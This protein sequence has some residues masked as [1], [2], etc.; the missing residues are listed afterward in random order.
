M[1]T[2][3]LTRIEQHRWHT[4]LTPQFDVTCH[5][6]GAGRAE[7]W[8][9]FVGPPGLDQLDEV[10]I[11]IRD[12][13]RGREAFTIAGGPTAEQIGQQVWG[14]YRFQPSADGADSNGR[15]VAPIE[16]ILGDQRRFA[17]QQ[18]PPPPWSNDTGGWRQQQAGQSVRLTFT[19]RRDGYEPWHVPRTVVVTP[20][21]PNVKA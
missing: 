13:I 1:A 15:S 8:V 12:D 11:T 7:L 20:K 9:E 2:E 19:C 3:R 17:L 16:L 6:T 14:P 5:E 4:D 18:T 21:E 10:T